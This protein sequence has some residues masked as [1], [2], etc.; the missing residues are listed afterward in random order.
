ML[1]SAELAHNK[2]YTKQPAYIDVCSFWCAL[3][4]HAPEAKRELIACD[5]VEEWAKHY[6]LLN[7]AAVPQWIL[8]GAQQ[9]R[10]A[11]Q[12]PH[13]P[14]F[15]SGVQFGAD[16]ASLMPVRLKPTL[17]WGNSIWPEGAN[18]GEVAFGWYDPLWSRRANVRRDIMSELERQ[19]DAELDRIDR[20]SPGHVNR[21][22]GQHFVLF[23]RFQVA[24]VP[25]RALVHEIG[26]NQASRIRKALKSTAVRLSLTLRREPAGRPRR[27]EL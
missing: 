14:N 2:G 27:K 1:R 3:H 23:I 18:T 20:D 19:V 10:A 9:E 15:V 8:E 17:T 16:N 22:D 7:G 26:E 24:E 4:E 12:R 21:K 6:H 11:F 25:V 13:P 5:N